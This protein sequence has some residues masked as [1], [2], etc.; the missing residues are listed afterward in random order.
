V[1][2][3]VDF[4]RELQAVPGAQV[5][6]GRRCRPDL[7]ITADAATLRSIVPANIDL[8]LDPGAVPYVE[9][10]ETQIARIV[11]NLV[12]NACD[13]MPHGGVLT[14]TTRCAAPGAVPWAD[15]NETEYAV[16]AIAD[17]GTG[18]DADTRQRIFE[19]YFTTKRGRGTG[20]GL[21]SVY[22]IVEQLGGHIEVESA[23]GAGSAFVVHLPAAGI[24]DRVG[25]AQRVSGALVERT[26]LLADDDDR[27]RDV[28]RRTL[29]R[30][31]F[32]VLEAADAAAALDIARCAGKTI[33]LLCTDGIMPGLETRRLVE[34][35]EKLHPGRPILICSGHLDAELLVRGIRAGDYAFLA[36][37]FRA[38]ELVAR[39]QGLLAAH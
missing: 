39:V 14:V 4:T 8:R 27:V 24:A 35:F 10:S 34:E 36:K 7:A 33:D 20:L 37:P 5:Q 16:I 21:A 2:A 22:G 38:R 1:R 6:R 26:I 25:A 18:M 28:M 13:A 17:S 19:P 23:I 15:P 11:L 9:L 12:M 31:G 30:A 3:S 29:Q 32:A